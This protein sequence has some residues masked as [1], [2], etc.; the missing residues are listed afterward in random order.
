[1]EKRFFHTCLLAAVG[2]WGS[3]NFARADNVAF[4]NNLTFYGDEEGFNGPFRPEETL[5]GQQ[6]K[7][8][9]AAPTGG[10]TGIEAGVL[11]TIPVVG[12]HPSI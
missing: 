6:L 7:S 9:F 2:W 11:W 8:S 3:G 1:M 12:T 5:F 4:Q 10:H